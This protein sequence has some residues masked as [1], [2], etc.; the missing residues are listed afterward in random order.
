MDDL[1]T[2]LVLARLSRADARDLLA[3]DNR[4]EL[5]SL[6]REAGAIGD[7]MAADR[8]LHLEGLLTELEFAGGGREYQADLAAVG[9][10]IAD[11][12]QAGVIAALIGDPAATRTRLGPGKRR[13]VIDTLMTIRS[14]RRRRGARRDGVRGGGLSIRGRSSSAGGTAC[15]S[16]TRSARPARSVVQQPGEPGPD[17]RG[18]RRRRRDHLR[19]VDL[20]RRGGTWRGVTL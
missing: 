15:G 17:V 14:C 2:R 6:H 13:T 11:A 1:V 10:K 3:K 12:G 5:T 18:Q 20:D 16:C 19:D 8:R 7:L 4:D 9:Q